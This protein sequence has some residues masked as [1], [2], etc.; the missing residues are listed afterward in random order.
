[1]LTELTRRLGTWF[2]TIFRQRFGHVNLVFFISFGFV[3]GETN[4]YI[5]QR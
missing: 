1:M 4:Q 5:T 3:L 2:R